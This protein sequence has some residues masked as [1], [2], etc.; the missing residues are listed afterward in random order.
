MKRKQPEASHEARSSDSEDLLVPIGLNDSDATSSSSASSGSNADGDSIPDDE[1]AVDTPA[2]AQR[3]QQIHA[4]HAAKPPDDPEP[5][6]PAAPARSAPTL[7][8]MR[9]PIAI[10]GG[11]SVPL[12]EVKGLHPQLTLALQEAG[13]AQLFPVQAAAWRQLAGG[14]SQAHDLCISAPTGSG[15]TLAYAL[16]VLSALMGQQSTA[17]RAL[18]VLPTRDLALQV[19]RV[20]ALLCPAAGLR[21][22][23][24]GGKA[25][26]AVEA[27]A[28]VP[29]LDAEAEPGW[30]GRQQGGADIVVA[31][32]GRLVAHLQGTPGFGLAGLQF[33]VV[34]EA[35]RLLRQAYQD[36]LPQVLAAIARRS[37]DSMA[38]V[39]YHGGSG[40][41]GSDYDSW[42]RRLVK[43]V[44]SATLT[45]DP[46]KIQRLGLHCPRYIAV[47]AED[48]R[49]KLPRQLQEYKLLCKDAGKPL[50]LLAL[51]ARRLA[52]QPTLV[53]AASVETAHR[54]HTFLSAT[55][56][57]LGRCVEFSSLV[58]PAARA[59]NL[60]AFRSGAAQVLVCSDA[61]TR[62]MDVENVANVVN[63][64]APVYSKTYVHRC[65]RTARAG[66]AGRA[67]TLVRK[68]DMRHFKAMLRK[69]D[70]TFVKDLK[71]RPEETAALR[72]DYEKALAHAQAAAG[73]HAAG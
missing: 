55:E 42:Q 37:D 43:V 11:A 62:G 39:G 2:A 45:R 66:K 53:F 19:F 14:H 12:A 35:D 60:A 61:M 27:A 1:E 32:P 33:L 54:V 4:E 13:F 23:L 36:W 6:Q 41:L 64:D 70:N 7:P 58:G 47:S 56:A 44:A 25:T 40:S 10:E 46:S 68:E 73:M 16:P 34:D 72:K 48:H 63:Y 22:V 17:V 67:F 65:G 51:L 24:I 49:Y 15:K 20:F 29:G 59:A 71:L 21:T 52:G 50:A 28:L 38:A 57:L 69:V 5:A 30:G 3:Q 31:T 18:A 9:V 26:Q 8:W